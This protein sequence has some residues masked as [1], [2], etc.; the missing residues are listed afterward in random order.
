MNGVTLFP[1]YPAEITFD[2]AADAVPKFVIR[3]LHSAT[4]GIEKERK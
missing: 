3:D 2:C 1:G 4:Y